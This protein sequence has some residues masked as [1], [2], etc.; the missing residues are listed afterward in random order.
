MSDC[1]YDG[2]QAR[3]ENGSTRSQ[4]LYSHVEKPMDVCVAPARADGACRSS[5]RGCRNPR[6]CRNVQRG[7]C[8]EGPGRVRP[9]RANDERSRRDRDHHVDPWPRAGRLSSEKGRAIEELA[10]K[11]AKDI[12]YEGVY[13]LISKEDHVFSQPLVRERYESVLPRERRQAVRE[14]FRGEFKNG[15]FDAGLV[16]GAGLLA[17]SLGG[18]PHGGASA[19]GS[20]GPAARRGDAGKFGL[21]TL[22][23]IGLGIFGVLVLMGCWVGFSNVAAGILLRREWAE[24]V[25]AWGQALATGGQATVTAGLAAAASSPACSAALAALLPATGSMTSSRDATR[26]PGTRRRRLHPWRGP[27]I[28]GSRRRCIRRRG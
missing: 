25:P 16:K 27:R 12:R 3:L 23:M 21:G 15:H 26:E 17:E 10:E 28:P 6:P 4:G 9:E 1:I 20:R 22:L 14:A 19:C 7:G 13:L 2:F 18:G 8:E 24:W 11:K 5:A